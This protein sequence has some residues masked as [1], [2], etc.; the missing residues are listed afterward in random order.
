MPL[1]RLDDYARTAIDSIVA[2][3]LRNIDLVLAVHRGSAEVP[4]RLPISQA[5]Q[6]AA[7]SWIPVGESAGGA[8]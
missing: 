8:Q 7:L 6:Y 5:M 1:R 2:Q 4:H 3:T